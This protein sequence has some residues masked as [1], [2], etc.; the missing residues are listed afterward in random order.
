ML[1]E[2]VTSGGAA[3]LA[4]HS[5]DR[6][7]RSRAGSGRKARRAPRR[8]RRA[9]LSAAAA[10]HGP[11]AAAARG[12]GRSR[13]SSR[14]RRSPS[15]ARAT[16]RSPASRFARDAR[17]RTRRAKATPS[18]PAWRA[19][20]TRRRIR[21]AWRPARSPCWPAGSTTPTRRRISSFAEEIAERGGAVDLGNAVRLGAA[22]QGFSAPQP[23]DRRPVA[24]AGRRRGGKPLRLADQRTAG[25]RD[26]PAGVRRARLAA[27]SARGRLQPA[28]QGRRD[29]GHR[30]ARRAST[31]IAPL[32]GMRQAERQAASPAFDAPPDFST[33]PPPGDNDRARVVEALGPTPVGVDEII[34]HTGLQ[35]AQVFTIL[36]ELDL[37]GRLERH[38]GGA[39]VACLLSTR[40]GVATCALLHAGHC[41]WMQACRTSRV[42][43]RKIHRGLDREAKRSHLTSSFEKSSG[44][45]K[46]L[47]CA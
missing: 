5:V 45:I 4:A 36:L 2:L 41:Q 13:R 38:Q 37:A 47:F 17:R 27:R 29:P 7:S 25:R 35:P 46:T 12:Q 16:P 20:S 43:A 11:A 28:A 24:R 22:R 33:T 40:S 32:A 1:P 19:A 15:S 18:F 44:R 10:A 34:R 31:Q 21:A 3:T 30:S 26:G 9:G 42:S 6:R 39:R 14:C 8:H 23:A